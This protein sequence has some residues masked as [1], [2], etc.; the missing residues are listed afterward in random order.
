MGTRQ[1]RRAV[2]S[3]VFCVLLAAVLSLAGAVLKPGRSLLTD[4]AGAA[5]TGWLE[6][7][8]NSIDVAF[9]GNSH[10]FNAVDASVLW[11][12]E[13]ISS[14]VLAGPTQPLEVTKYYVREALRTQDLDVV[15]VELSSITNDRERFVRE[16][17]LINVGYMPWSLNKVGAIAF[18]TPPG[19]RQAAACDLW[20]Y[21]SR[22]SE[23]T[24]RDFQLAT[25]N[26][27]DAFLK[28]WDPRLTSMEVT[29]TP[30]DRERSIDDSHTVR[31]L[32]F[33]AEHLRDIALTCAEN[34][35]RL[36]LVLTPTGPPRGYSAIF[37]AATEPLLAEFDHVRVLDLS[38]P[39]AVPG[40]S[41][42]TD[43][44]DGGHV[45][46]TGAEKTSRVLAEYLAETYGLTDHRSDP[47]YARWDADARKR[48]AFLAESLGAQ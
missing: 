20:A 37:D 42:T 4:E 36:L 17:H 34:D 11:R 3:A 40:I 15:V 21:H 39:G 9:F 35:V 32:A 46:H 2:Y 43:F 45:S 38:E 44:Y 47:A 22:W 29:A 18:A 48:D 41:Y 19:E 8:P 12:R 25:K 13:G 6:H 28:G 33:N 16:F 14:Y 10:T 27:G 31:A 5:W 1:V 23:L 30:V 24:T 26:G 7:E